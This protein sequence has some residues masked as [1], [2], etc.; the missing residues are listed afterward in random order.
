MKILYFISLIFFLGCF[1]QEVEPNKFIVPK[2]YNNLEPA[3]AGIE[4]VTS[5]G[6]K[7]TTSQE[8]E[9]GYNINDKITFK[10]SNIILGKID[11]NT[12]NTDSKLTLFDLFGFT[13][14]NK[15]NPRYIY[16]W[17]FLF[18]LSSKTDQGIVFI[19]KNIKE[20][21]K[22]Q[23]V[24]TI[25]LKD[26]N[27]EDLEKITTKL[28]NR[29]WIKESV[30]VDYFYNPRDIW[31][32]ISEGLIIDAD[33]TGYSIDI[34]TLK[35]EQIF[36]EK[37]IKKEYRNETAKFYPHLEELNPDLFYLYKVKNGFFQDSNNDGLIDRNIT[38][39]DTT[40][41]YKKYQFNQNSNILKPNR[42]TI[43]LF[44]KGSWFNKRESLKI[45]STANILY[46]YFTYPYC[47]NNIELCKDILDT[48]S[49]TIL[50]SD[51][52]ED[53]KISSEDLYFFDPY[54]DWD[55]S[56]KN[57]NIQKYNELVKL[58]KEDRKDEIFNLI[59]FD[60]SFL[61]NFKLSKSTEY[62]NLFKKYGDY[63]FLNKL[64]NIDI[65]DLTNYLKPKVTYSLDSFVE[66][67]FIDMYYKPAERRSPKEIKL[68]FADLTGVIQLYSVKENKFGVT[69]RIYTDSSIHKSFFI[70]K[71][72]EIIYIDEVGIKM[73]AASGDKSNHVD[74][75]NH[76]IPSKKQIA[77][78]DLNKT[79]T[80]STIIVKYPER[81]A[82]IT[83][84]E[85]SDAI[86]VIRTYDT[87]FTAARIMKRTPKLELV[88]Q[89][90]YI[91]NP[92][93]VLLSQDRLRMYILSNSGIDTY[94]FSLTGKS[95]IRID[96]E[97]SKKLSS[98]ILNVAKKFLL[99]NSDRE[100]VVLTDDNKLQLFSV[101]NKVDFIKVGHTLTMPEKIYDIKLSGD[102]NRLFLLG[103]KKI[104]IL[105][106]SILRYYGF[107]IKNKLD[108][109]AI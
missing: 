109:V 107:Y 50:T 22:K 94:K 106:L 64:R 47:L 13:E 102:E 77:E 31:W 101:P 80:K 82:I 4:Y 29:N 91:E 96:Q 18:S 24:T 20:T 37:T 19:P 10:I 51:L 93:Q 56:S 67:K 7:G 17:Q 3:I 62:F 90:G 86:K 14:Y 98:T 99:I 85:G 92:R 100:A 54:L 75:L 45:T 61:S 78:Y 6:I 32:Q 25:E 79:D 34:K 2:F 52:N 76:T 41:V 15:K 8:G 59:F 16:I 105:D 70:N 66:N 57:F 53:E 12:I 1:D 87:P 81:R 21:L 68:L 43:N 48:W 103:E 36:S 23:L 30:I 88:L 46:K 83:V 73:I 44:F 49:Q 84:S 65:L 55:K 42:R 108:K 58:A 38:R 95:G 39:R 11:T 89:K 60:V 5:S 72:S 63:I 71:D 97:D 69:H 27:K 28:L 104:Y 9:F 74:Y 33:I 26:L 40:N 35:K